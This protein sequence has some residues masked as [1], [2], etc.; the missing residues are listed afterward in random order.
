MSCRLIKS[1][2]KISI[3]LLLVVLDTAIRQPSEQLK[4]NPMKCE[5]TA[6]AVT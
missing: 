3:F 4:A 6:A 5:E 2:Q 1:T